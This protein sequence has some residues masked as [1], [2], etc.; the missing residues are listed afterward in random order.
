MIRGYRIVLSFDDIKFC[1]KSVIGISLF[2]LVTTG[3]RYGNSKTNIW[4]IIP[5]QST[6][7]QP[8]ECCTKHQL[9][10]TCSFIMDCHVIPTAVSFQRRC[11]WWYFIN[12]ALLRNDFTNVKKK[13]ILT[14][15]A[16]TF[17]SEPHVKPIKKKSRFR[18]N[19]RLKLYPRGIS[20]YH[21]ET[22]LLNNVTVKTLCCYVRM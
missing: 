3:N 21:V 9:T 20:M 14:A 15:R 11:N 19:L 18:T 17:D 22:P 13:D 8:S 6:D 4:T 5:K 1:F 10:K 12:A 7:F 2:R 16:D